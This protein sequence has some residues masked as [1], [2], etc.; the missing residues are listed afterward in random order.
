ME[1]P[2]TAEVSSS[3]KFTGTEY[4]RSAECSNKNSV[5]DSTTMSDNS[6]LASKTAWTATVFISSVCPV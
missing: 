1:I 2:L 6:L 4:W 3:C 5:K